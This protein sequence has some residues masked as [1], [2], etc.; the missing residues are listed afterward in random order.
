MPF[1]ED[2]NDRLSAQPL[3]LPP[4][5]SWLPKGQTEEECG[6]K[7]YVFASF[8]GVFSTSDFAV[9]L[10]TRFAGHLIDYS[11]IAT[12]N[13]HHFDSLRGAPPPG[14]GLRFAHKR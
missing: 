3:T 8:P 2:A 7:T 6:R 12:G 14:E 10:P 4:G 11:V 9:P 1:G 5:G 13:H